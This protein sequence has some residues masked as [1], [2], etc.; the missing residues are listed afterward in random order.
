MELGEQSCQVLRTVYHNRRGVS[1][2]DRG[3]G[4][5][6]GAGQEH[7]LLLQPRLGGDTQDVLEPGRLAILQVLS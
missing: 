4:A 7:A 3:C 6:A 2:E 1:G 5:Y